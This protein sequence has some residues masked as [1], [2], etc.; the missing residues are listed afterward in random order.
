MYF[1]ASTNKD[2][3]N[4]LN[5]I[6]E[7]MDEAEAFSMLRNI[8]QKFG[9]SGTVFTPTDVEECIINRREADGLEPLTDEQLE[10]AVS[11]V[12][13]S[14]DWSKWLPDWMTEQGWDIINSA[15]YE[16]VENADN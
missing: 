10:E 13:D 11:A 3:N 15:I 7:D 5:S 4:L 6:M 9:W 8:E 12:V 14:R 16:R 1:W 2:R